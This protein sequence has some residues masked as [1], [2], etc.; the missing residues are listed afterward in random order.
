MPTKPKPL[1]PILVLAKAIQ[2]KAAKKR[3]GLARKK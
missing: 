1:P 2:D 3:A